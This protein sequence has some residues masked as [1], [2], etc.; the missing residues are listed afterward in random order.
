MCEPLGSGWINNVT[1]YA[2]DSDNN[3]TDRVMKERLAEVSRWKDAGCWKDNETRMIPNRA[4]GVHT[5]ESCR[6][7]ANTVNA[8]VFALQNGDEC[9]TMNEPNL[10]SPI[11]KSLGPAGSCS[12]QGDAWVNRVYSL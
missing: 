3:N 5:I 6:T 4:D 9:Y 10:N 2:S 7:R 12:P 8:N 1:L 11:Y